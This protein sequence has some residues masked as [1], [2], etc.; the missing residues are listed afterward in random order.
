MGRGVDKNST[1]KVHM[2]LLQFIAMPN[3]Y[4]YPEKIQLG[5]HQREITKTMKERQRL[6][7]KY[8]DKERYD[9]VKNEIAD[10]MLVEP[11]WL[12]K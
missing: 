11:D 9:G 10:F 6:Q 5:Y 3:C 4:K 1:V 2:I 12:N 8:Y 7:K